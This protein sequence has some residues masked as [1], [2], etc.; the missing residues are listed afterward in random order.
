MPVLSSFKSHVAHSCRP[1]TQNF[2]FS[3]LPKRKFRFC[4]NENDIVFRWASSNPTKLNLGSLPSVDQL[5]FQHL[6]CRCIV[7]HRSLLLKN[8]QET[9]I[10]KSWW[11]SFSI[12]L[13]E[14]PALSFGGIDVDQSIYRSL[15]DESAG[16]SF[17]SLSTE[18]YARIFQGRLWHFANSV[19]RRTV[20]TPNP[21]FF[22]KIGL[23]RL[24]PT[25]FP[26]PQF[27]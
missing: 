13:N 21:I 11:S 9:Q 15:F 7:F 14:F 6:V 18:G 26:R 23:S 27:R 10:S 20:T 8:P 2:R 3:V 24:N 22:E 1:L 12:L 5:S 25:G 4:D 17:E 19:D 16:N